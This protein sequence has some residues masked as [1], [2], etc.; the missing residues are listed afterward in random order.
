MQDGFYDAT[1]SEQ[2]CSCKDLCFPSGWVDSTK[3]ILNKQLCLN[4]IFPGL[5][6]PLEPHVTPLMPPR[7]LAL[8]EAVLRMPVLAAE[9]PL[10]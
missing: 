3:L 4:A 6:V 2:C 5:L 7:C 9:P 8:L 10:L 1:G